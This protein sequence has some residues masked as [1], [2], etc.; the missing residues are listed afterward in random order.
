MAIHS[1]MEIQDQVAKRSWQPTLCS[2]W[3][4]LLFTLVIKS[5]KSFWNPERLDPDIWSPFCQCRGDNN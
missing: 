2:L 3:N 5:H 4:T 1:T